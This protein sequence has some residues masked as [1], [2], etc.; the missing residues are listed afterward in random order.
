M[1]YKARICD[2]ITQTFVS[3]NTIEDEYDPEIENRRA[4]LFVCCM[5]NLMLIFQ[6][7]EDEEIIKN[8]CH[9]VENSQFFTC[10][11]EVVRP[12]LCEDSM[13]TNS[14]RVLLF[15]LTRSLKKRLEGDLDSVE[16]SFYEENDVIYMTKENKDEK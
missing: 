14:L 10:Q 3:L 2:T 7:D 1:N 15:I 13:E 11:E 8:M 12:L 4:Q 5:K 16:E 9:Y 6:D